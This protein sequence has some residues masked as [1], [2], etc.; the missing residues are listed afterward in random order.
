MDLAKPPGEPRVIRLQFALRNQRTREQQE[1]SKMTMVRLP[2]MQTRPLR[3][4]LPTARVIVAVLALHAWPPFSTPQVGPGPTGAELGTIVTV[5]G[6]GNAV[7]CD[8][9]PATNAQLDSPEAVAVDRWGNL[10]IADRGNHRVRRV[11]VAGVITTSAGTGEPRYSG[12]GGSATNASFRA[13]S[14]VAVDSSGNLYI[15]DSPH[16]RVRKV[17]AAGVITTVAGTGQRGYSGDGGPA[18]SAQLASP[19]RVAVDGSG[20]LYIVD[21]ERVRK[22]DAAGV[23]TTVA[24]TGQRGYSGD[25]GPAASAQLGLLRGV[26]V[27]GSGNLYIADARNHRVRKVDA[28][29]AINTVAGTGERRYGGDGGPATSAQLGRPQ[30]VAVDSS[31]NLYIAANYNRRVRRV[32]AAGVINTVA[33]TGQW[34]H[35]GDG[36]PATSAQLRSPH[37]VA[38]DGLGNLYIADTYSSC[39]RRVD[40][41]GVITTVAGTGEWG[42]SGDGGPAT[43][44]QLQRPRGV[45]VDGL[46]NLY[47]ADSDNHCVRRVDTAGV[48]TTVAGTGERGYSGDG[49]PPTSAQLRSPQGVAVDGLGNLYVAD[50]LNHRVRRVDAAGVITTVA[51]TDERGYSGDGGPATSAQLGAPRGVA[52]DGSGNLYIADY[53]NGRVRKVD[54]AGVITTVAGTGQRGYSGDG[55]PAASAQLG[56]LRGVAVDGS[57]NLY[58]ADARNHRVRKVDATGAINT[59]AGTGERRYGGDGGPATSAQLGRPQGVAVDSS[60]NLYIAANYNRRV[61]RVDAAGVINTVAGTGQWGHSGDGGPATSAQLRSPHGVAVDGLGNLYIADTYSSCVRRVDTAGVITTVA[62]TGEWG[63]SGDGGPATNAQLQRPRGVAVD[64]LGNLYI[65]DSDNHC[66]RRVDTAG[67]ITTVAGTGER[68]YSGDGGPPT[69]AQLRSPQGVAVDGLGNLY[70]ADYLNHR[71]RRVDAAGVITTVAGTDERGYSGDGGPAT[72]A[73]LGAPRGVAV[74]GS[75]NLYI[76]DYGN[77]RVR[78]VDAAGVITT[79]AGTGEWGYSGDG[80]P[81]TSALLASPQDVAVDGLGNLYV[82][83]P[84]H[85]R[86]RRVD[87]AE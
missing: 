83:D 60:G 77:G 2:A 55:G 1:E 52:V 42:Y 57:G 5:A 14:G 6:D 70:V 3:P 23:I 69:S 86:V 36:G 17:D 4:A 22:V 80:G 39:V 62:G 18:A 64:G 73:Q 44:A 25:G 33:G 43:N 54:A 15:A 72:S 68:G 50:Y 51:G 28:T 20:N 46:G 30:G 75:G 47:I 21:S 41:A 16:N 78:R 11:D 87:L 53:G 85:H 19:V 65:A 37:G 12:D 31:G 35:S 81:G 10:Y 84:W 59:V 13:P 26:A 29:G 76:A 48:I 9:G 45:A 63:Y 34:G 40:T 38:V 66:V 49:G 56:L 24:G 27:D 82:A 71:V 58:I 32:D 61:R 67:V 8:G 74:D 79:V 7:L